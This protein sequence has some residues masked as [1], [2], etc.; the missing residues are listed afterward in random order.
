[1]RKSILATVAVVVLLAWAVAVG[2]CG[3]SVPAFTDNQIER[4]ESNIK[5]AEGVRDAG[6]EQDGRT[7]T[8]LIITG[9]S[10]SREQARTLATNFMR[11]A[12]TWGPEDHRGWELVQGI[13]DYHIGVM[14]PDHSILVDGAKFHNRSEIEWSQ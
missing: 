8:L 3:E 2:A 7:V 9:A 14:Y 10:T 11:N 13:Y 6:M 12:M 5:K 4:I 1:M